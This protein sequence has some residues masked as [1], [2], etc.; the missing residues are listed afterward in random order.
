MGIGLQPWQASSP[1]DRVA[2]LQWRKTSR[3]EIEIS[4][5]WLLGKSIAKMK[6]ILGNSDE[7]RGGLKRRALQKAVIGIA[8]ALGWRW[9]L[10]PGGL[11]GQV[12]DGGRERTRSHNG[13]FLTARSRFPSMGKERL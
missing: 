1:A 6:N 10:Q 13:E 2:E 9:T 11:P 5:R 3:K 7:S 8:K 4:N 12:R